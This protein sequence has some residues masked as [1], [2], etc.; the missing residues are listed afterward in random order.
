VVL[1]GGLDGD[2]MRVWVWVWV[3][4]A[5]VTV[6]ALRAVGFVRDGRL[7][8]LEITSSSVDFANPTYEGQCC[9]T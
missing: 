4:S 7:R 9:P 3:W 8:C 1:T 6:H 5:P 2:E